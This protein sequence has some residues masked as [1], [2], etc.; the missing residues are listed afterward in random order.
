MCTN[1]FAHSAVNFTSELHFVDNKICLS[2]CG[3]VGTGLIFTLVMTLFC[4]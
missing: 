2:L 1:L 4:S 3:A